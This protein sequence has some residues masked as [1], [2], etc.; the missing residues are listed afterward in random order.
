MI[1]T[2]TRMLACLTQ[3]SV[4]MTRA[5]GQLSSIQLSHTMQAHGCPCVHSAYLPLAHSICMCTCLH[6]HCLTAAAGLSA[7]Y[8]WCNKWWTIATMERPIAQH[9]GLPIASYRDVVWSSIIQPDPLMPCLWNGLSHADA[10]GH[11]L[12]ADVVAYAFARSVQDSQ[13]D[14]QQQLCEVP[15]SKE[16]AKFHQQAQGRRYCAPNSRPGLYMT[17][18]Q[19]GF[20]PVAHSGCWSFYEDRPGKPGARLIDCA[21]VCVLWLSWY[22]LFCW[23]NCAV[24]CVSC[25]SVTDW[26]VAIWELNFDY[27]TGH[28]RCW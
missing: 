23:V 12:F 3:P 25:H 24:T 8:S 5:S 19:P 2:T 18:K 7:Q 26:F 6:T 16:P 15:E 22:M 4:A 9:H 1:H 14:Q 17:A 20:T 11:M 13:R 27:S 10:L 28:C 21:L